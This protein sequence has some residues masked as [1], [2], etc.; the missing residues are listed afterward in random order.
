M[1][2]PITF[3][4]LTKKEQET[5]IRACKMFKIYNVKTKTFN[6]KSECY[7]LIMLFLMKQY[8]I[9][10]NAMITWSADFYTCLENVWRM[11]VYWTDEGKAGDIPFTIKVDPT[12]KKAIEEL[13]KK[14]G[15]KYEVS[16]L[17]CYLVRMNEYL[18]K[19]GA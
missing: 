3:F 15:V 10:F 1:P 18:D 19:I 12:L 16:L 6:N 17:R 11:G 2:S 4:K 13:R 5:L 7:K 9:S 8:K 14:V